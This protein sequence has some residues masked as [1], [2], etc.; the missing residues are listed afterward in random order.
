MSD[1]QD[2]VLRVKIDSYKDLQN[3]IHNE[4]KLTKPDVEKLIEK[5]TYA[6]LNEKLSN[7]DWVEKY[8]DRN[9]EKVVKDVISKQSSST[10]WN[11]DIK[12]NSAIEKCI[13]QYIMDKV[14][15]QLKNVTL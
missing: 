2:V 9:I 3:I 15:E 7:V 1:Y 10:S 4:L 12:I 6:F 5:I 11:L 14:K 8:I 13:G